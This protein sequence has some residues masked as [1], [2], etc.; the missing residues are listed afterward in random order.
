M[1]SVL[2]NFGDLYIETR[3]LEMPRYINVLEVLSDIL[4]RLNQVNSY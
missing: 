3:Y 2:M 4:Q 1:A